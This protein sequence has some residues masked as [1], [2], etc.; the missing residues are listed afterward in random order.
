MQPQVLGLVAE[1]NLIRLAAPS[2]YAAVKQTANATAADLRA[3]G[4]NVNLMA[5]V[6]V[7]TAWGR[8]GGNAVYAG[9][10]ADFADFPFMQTLGLSSYPYFGWSAPEDLPVDYCERLRNGRSIPAMVVEGGWA[11][12]GLGSIVSSPTLQARYIE[13]HAD[14]LDRVGARACLQLVFADLDLASLPPPVLFVFLGGRVTEREART[15][16][17]AAPALPICSSP[18]GSPRG[19]GPADPALGALSSV[20]SVRDARSAGRFQAE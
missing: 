7:E 11:S 6:Q 16:S 2:L 20:P 17:R 10:E 14:L 8:L 13:R 12:R 9:V 5:S 4:S 3:A 15:G 19:A 1:C 18:S